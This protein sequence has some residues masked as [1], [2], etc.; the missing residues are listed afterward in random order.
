MKQ[1]IASVFFDIL[2]YTIGNI[3]LCI[4]IPVTELTNIMIYK[5]GIKEYIFCKL[6]N[7]SLIL[8]ITFDYTIFYLFCISLTTKNFVELAIDS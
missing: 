4:F 2:S 5:R 1:I 3:I 7:N 8:K 6:K